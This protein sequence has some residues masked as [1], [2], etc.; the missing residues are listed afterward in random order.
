MPKTKLGKWA[1]GLI[2]AFVGFLVALV[3]A[4]RLAGL[5]P[6]TP[7]V[8]ALGTCMALSGIAAFVAGLVALIKLK[9]RTFAVYLAVVLGFLASLISIMEMVEGLVSRLTH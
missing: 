5:A 3:L 2:A 7:V 8:I 1:G 6:G 4:M 9:D